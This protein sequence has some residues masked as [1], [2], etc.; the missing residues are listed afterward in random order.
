MHHASQAT[1]RTNGERTMRMSRLVL[2][3]AAVLVVTGTACHAAGNECDKLRAGLADLKK[4]R[5]GTV[6]AKAQLENAA[7]EVERLSRIWEAS[8]EDEDF[9]RIL[10]ARTRH[11]SLITTFEVLYPTSLAS[12]DRS[13]AHEELLLQKCEAI[14]AAFKSPPADGQPTTPSSIKPSPASTGPMTP[15]IS[16]MPVTIPGVGVINMS[17]NPNIPPPSVAATPSPTTTGQCVTKDG[18]V[19][20]PV[21][22]PT[23]AKR[24]PMAP[25]TPASVP[26]TCPPGSEPMKR[27]AA[28]TANLDQAVP[29]PP[30]PAQG[31]D[32]SQAEAAMMKALE[33]LGAIRGQLAQYHMI[34]HGITQTLPRNEDEIQDR[35]KIAQ[36]IRDFQELETKSQAAYEERVYELGQCRSSTG[37]TTPVTM[38]PA[39]P[40]KPITVTTPVLIPPTVIPTTLPPSASSSPTTTPTGQC[41][42]KDGKVVPPVPAPT[43]AK[44]GPMA[45]PTPASASAPTT[46]PPGSVPMKPPAASSASLDQAVPVPPSPVYVPP[47]PPALATTAPVYVPPKPPV[48]VPAVTTHLPPVTPGPTTTHHPPKPAGTASTMPTTTSTHHPPKPTGTTWTQPVHK[49]SISRHHPTKPTGTTTTQPVHKTVTSRHHPTKPTKTTS[50]T[51]VRTNVY[52]PTGRPTAVQQPH[53]KRRGR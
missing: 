2:S 37:N 14:E 47:K 34:N 11:Q 9:Q 17:I 29:M 44:R 32:C 4:D 48:Y 24:G 40:G 50:A 22:A 41:I 23:V 38:Q 42:T 31:Q 51:Q 35:Q 43:V 30:S 10:E 1:A 15:E 3:V 27:P 12:L 39:V 6:G 25:P 52:A 18:K 19:V 33:H 7:R 16:T 36:A 26:T 5:A 8:G 53:I 49:T 46:C 20:P 28:G 21:P 13:I 45:P